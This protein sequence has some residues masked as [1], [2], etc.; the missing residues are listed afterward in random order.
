MTIISFYRWR[1]KEGDRFRFKLTGRLVTVSKVDPEGR[2]F[3]DDMESV[4]LTMYNRGDIHNLGDAWERYS[5]ILDPD[6]R[7]RLQEEDR[8]RKSNN[9]IHWLKKNH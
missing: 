1:I 8:K 2:V 6:E 9:I 5:P 4:Y 3:I 7:R